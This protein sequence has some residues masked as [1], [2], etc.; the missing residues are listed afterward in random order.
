MTR[1]LEEVSGRYRRSQVAIDDILDAMVLFVLGQFDPVPLLDQTVIDE[2]GISANMMI[3]AN[4]L[5]DH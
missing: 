5:V 3:P 2:Y 4:P 1:L